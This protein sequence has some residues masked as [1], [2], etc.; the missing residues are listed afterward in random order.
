M[1]A[2]RA[3]AQRKCLPLLMGLFSGGLGGPL[4]PAFPLLF[5]KPGHARILSQ[6]FV[7]RA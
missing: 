7:V 1:E 5:F 6:E 2:P 3:S 4:K